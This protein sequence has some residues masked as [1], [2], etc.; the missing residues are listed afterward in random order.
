RDLL[1][2]LRN[3]AVAK[4]PGAD[5]PDSPLAD[6][7]DQEASGLKAL[8]ARA[9][10]R[11]LMRLF[12]LLAEAQE[13]LIRSPYPDLILEMALMRM[14]T[15]APVIDA[16]EL[17]RA[18]G[19]TTRGTGGGSGTAPSP[20]A[21]AAGVTAAAVGEVAG[22]RR[23]PI[24]GEVNASAPRRTVPASPPAV[25]EAAAPD[26]LPDLR[27]FIRSRRAALAGFMEQ[28]A[29]LRVNDDTLTVTPRSEIYVRYLS[30]NRSAIAELATELYGRRMRVEI[31]T[32]TAEAATALPTAAA[33]DPA[34]AASA[35]PVRIAADAPPPS[36]VNRDSPGAVAPN[37]SAQKLSAQKISTEDRQALYAD[38][39]VK[40]IFSEFEA[41]FVEIRSDPLN[42]RAATAEDPAS[43]K[44]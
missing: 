25:S 17:L 35:Q 33:A 21:A 16:D 15:L 37:T 38:P 2:V 30:D 19:A 40:R 3:L 10:A 27:D 28:G 34:L 36:S 1:E 41:R 20:P 13:Q 26:D 12:H 6:L 44:K 11:D 18:I 24:R 31:A 9:S 43:S 5:G 22:A 4:L 39:V 29:A 8:A 42:P 7:P 14:A 32:G 23:I